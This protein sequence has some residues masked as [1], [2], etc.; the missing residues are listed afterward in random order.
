MEVQEGRPEV[1]E[2]I[3]KVDHQEEEEDE[4]GFHFHPHPAQASPSSS[5][6]SEGRRRCTRCSQCASPASRTT[7]GRVHLG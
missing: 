6:H 5:G 4:V 1:H 2:E 3:L 7:N